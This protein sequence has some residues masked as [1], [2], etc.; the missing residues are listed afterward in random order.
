MNETTLPPTRIFIV[1]DDV[2]LGNIL[3]NKIKESNIQVTLFVSAETVLQELERTIP[4][5]LLLDIYLPGVDGLKALAQIRENPKTKDICVI[6]VSNTDEKKDRDEATRL[7]AQFLIKA[8]TDPD[9]ILRFALSAFNE[10]T[11]KV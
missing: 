1:E 4:D 5:I 6:I 3:T 7:G 2:F 11:K 8:V 9:E 10:S